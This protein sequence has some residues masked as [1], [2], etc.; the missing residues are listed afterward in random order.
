MNSS[1]RYITVML[2]AILSWSSA[3]SQTAREIMEK[4]H[5]RMRLAGVESRTILEIHDSRG[6]VRTRETTMASK[7]FKDGTEKRVIVF[8]SPADVK[9][10]GI[11]INDFKNKEDAMWIFM[12]ALRKTRKI[13][14]SEKGKSFMGS[15]FTNGD[16]SVESLDDFKYELMGKELVENV[17][18]WKIKT[19]PITQK[20]ATD[21]GI[22]EK[23]IWVA[24]SDYVP[25]K[26]EVH[27]L[28][29]V[30]LKEISFKGIKKVDPKSEKYFIT[31]MEVHNVQSKRYSV[32]R[33]EDLEYNPSVSEKYFTLS[34]LETQI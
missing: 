9:G 34:F 10:T 18:C 19:T 21:L 30:L 16:L 28:K 15:E 20:I 26:A 24:T 17:N 6:N 8:I 3:M 11:L 29:G 32:M 5:E 27:D 13:V 1:T 4:S 7:I 25:R 22:K 31:E 23:V 14:S 2:I 12:P 33:I